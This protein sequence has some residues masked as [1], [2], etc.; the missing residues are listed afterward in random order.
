[1]LGGGGVFAT[2]LLVFLV[3]GVSGAGDMFE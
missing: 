2:V 3:V 1:V